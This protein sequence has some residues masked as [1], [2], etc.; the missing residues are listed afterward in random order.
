MMWINS[1]SVSQNK[2]LCLNRQTLLNCRYLVATD[3]DDLSF[4]LRMPNRGGCCNY[5]AE[6][7]KYALSV[8]DNETF[9]PCRPTS[10]LHAACYNMIDIRTAITESKIREWTMRLYMIWR[11]ESRASQWWDAKKRTCITASEVYSPYRN[12]QSTRMYLMHPLASM[13]AGLYRARV[14]IYT[15]T[16]RVCCTNELYSLVHYAPTDKHDIYSLHAWAD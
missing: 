6:L 16:L 5:T 4:G 11:A 3:G 7:P 13:S 1:F 9:E 2:N 12:I 8:I 10:R 14:C 15:T